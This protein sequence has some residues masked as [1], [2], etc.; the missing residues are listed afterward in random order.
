MARMQTNP[1]FI[2][3][4]IQTTGSFACKIKNRALAVATRAEARVIA[5]STPFLRASGHSIQATHRN[6][7]CEPCCTSGCLTRTVMVVRLCPS[8]PLN[9]AVASLVALLALP[10][11][12]SRLKRPHF[13]VTTSRTSQPA[14]RPATFGEILPTRF[15][16]RERLMNSLKFI[17]H[18][19]L[20]LMSSSITS[21]KF[22][23]LPAKQ[24]LPTQKDLAAHLFAAHDSILLQ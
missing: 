21:P 15:F 10:V 24:R 11:K 20:T 12:R 17:M 19:K 16:S 14:I 7:A 3:L 13:L 1:R 8:R 22:L 18:T 4:L 5:T 9:Q 23:S 6:H 2:V